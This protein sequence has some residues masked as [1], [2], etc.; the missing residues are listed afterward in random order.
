MVHV[1]TCPLVVGATTKRKP[2]TN[3]GF[4]NFSSVFIVK[5]FHL[6]YGFTFNLVVPI[7]T[8]AQVKGLLF[9]IKVPGNPYSY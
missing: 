8:L 2:K 9:S 4:V 7:E 5:N 1:D 6:R 3:N